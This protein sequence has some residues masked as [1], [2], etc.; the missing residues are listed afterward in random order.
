MPEKLLTIED[1][2]TYINV[3]PITLYKMIKTG[4][5]PAF[6]IGGRWRFNQS[7]IDEWIAQKMKQSRPDNQKSP[8][9]LQDGI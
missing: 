8:P 1:V 3:H 5:I 4:E 9:S 7:E 2:C 6:K